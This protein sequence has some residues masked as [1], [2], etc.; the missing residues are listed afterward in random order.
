MSIHPEKTYLDN[1]VRS[2][3]FKEASADGNLSQI[4]FKLVWHYAIMTRVLL[5]KYGP[6]GPKRGWQ[7]IFGDDLRAYKFLKRANQ[8]S[9]EGRTFSDIVVEFIR[10]IKVGVGKV[11]AS[12]GLTAPKDSSL[13]EIQKLL[14]ETESFFEKGFWNVLKGQK[15]YLL[16]DDLD[17]G[18][19]P[20][21]DAQ[22]QL[23]RALFSVVAEYN[24]RE[25][26]KPVI[27]L[28]ADILAGL[29][30]PQR[31]KFFGYMQYVRW[32]TPLLSEMLALR[33]E[34]YYNIPAD[35]VHKHFFR[36]DVSG[37]P[38][39][40]F[41]VQNTLR[42]PRDLLMYAQAAIQEAVEQGDDYVFARHI[43]TAR[44]RYSKGRVYALHDEWGYLYSN[45]ETFLM[46]LAEEVSTEKLKKPLNPRELRD[47]L[48]AVR[49]RTILS[50][51]AGAP[52][53][54]VSYFPEGS[55]DPKELVSILYKVGVLAVNEDGQIY[56]EDLEP[57]LPK[58]TS[59]TVFEFHPMIVPFMEEYH[60]GDD[61]IWD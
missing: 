46:W 60:G 40:D 50:D 49:D 39:L 21:S 54:V 1:I 17:Q 53:W 32:T 45:L 59:N 43:K 42:R 34:N 37:T 14:K 5:A 29:K 26:V 36:G 57:E 24:H 48:G 28:R 18:W 44:H 10:E 16:F 25:R 30:L 13:Q 47:A 33:I 58:I 38:L 55:K 41:L 23:V 12:F 20:D 4:I 56:T 7:P 22:Q 52:L 11:S 6:D 51:D 9:A 8:L 27:A 61:T 31:E 15:L 19:D 3:A 2:T 35:K